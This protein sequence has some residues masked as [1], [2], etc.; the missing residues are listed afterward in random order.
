MADGI[1]RMHTGRVEQK[2]EKHRFRFVFLLVALTVLLCAGVC[3]RHFIEIGTP[4]TLK[5]IRFDGQILWRERRER[6]SPWRILSH[7]RKDAIDVVFRILIRICCRRAG[8]E[9]ILPM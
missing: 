3:V 9:P 7:R 5:F 1:R 8:A 2:K 6:Y 4:E